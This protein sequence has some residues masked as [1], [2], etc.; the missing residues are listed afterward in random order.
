MR[1][2]RSADGRR[3]MSARFGR[4]RKTLI[5]KGGMIATATS[6]AADGFTIE[7]ATSLAKGAI[8]MKQ[9]LSSSDTN[10]TFSRINAVFQQMNA[11]DYHIYVAWYLDG[12]LYSD[13]DPSRDFLRNAAAKIYI[14]VGKNPTGTGTGRQTLCF[15]PD[16]NI[17]VYARDKDLNPKWIKLINDKKLNT[18]RVMFFDKPDTLSIE[19]M[20]LENEGAAD[21]GVG[22]VDIHV[23]G[24]S[25]PIKA[26]RTCI[27]YLQPSPQVEL[28]NVEA[29]CEIYE[30]TKPVFTEIGGKS[31][32]VL[33]NF[34]YDFPEFI[35]LDDTYV[36]ESYVLVCTHPITYGISGLNVPCMWFT[37]L[38]KDFI[39]SIFE[40]TMQETAYFDNLP[41]IGKTLCAL[42]FAGSRSHIKAVHAED[43]L[44]NSIISDAMKNI[45]Y[46]QV[47]KLVVAL[48]A[49]LPSGIGTC[50]KVIDAVKSLS[51][52]I[53]SGEEFSAIH[54]VISA[55][56]KNN[57]LDFALFFKVFNVLPLIMIAYLK[58]HFMEY[59]NDEL[60]LSSK[61]VLSHEEIFNMLAHP[62]EQIQK[63]NLYLKLNISSL[64][65][66]NQLTGSLF[67]SG[68]TVTKPVFL[69]FIRNHPGYIQRILNNLS[70]CI[71][72][73]GPFVYDLYKDSSKSANTLLLVAVVEITQ[74]PGS[75][76]IVVLKL[77]PKIYV[78]PEEKVTYTVI[79]GY[80]SPHKYLCFVNYQSMRKFI[81]E[82][83]K[84]TAVEQQPTTKS[85]ITRLMS[86]MHNKSKPTTSKNEARLRYTDTLLAK[87][88]TSLEDVVR[89][90]IR[91]TDTV[92]R[93]R[94]CLESDI[95]TRIK[96]LEWL[97]LSTLPSTKPINNDDT[98]ILKACQDSIKSP[99]STLDQTYFRVKVEKQQSNKGNS[100]DATSDDATTKPAANKIPNNNRELD[101]RFPVKVEKKQ[102]YKGTS[103][104]ETNNAT[105]KPA[106]YK[107]PNNDMNLDAETNK[108]SIHNPMTGS[109]YRMMAT[110]I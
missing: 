31:N 98:T 45:D 2:E 43:N 46:A 26:S 81:Q 10:N 69:E 48:G 4:N 102:S 110:S 60:T 91:L 54:K 18:K 86:I 66:F 84:T 23:A 71:L 88:E 100:D 58:Q 94:Q 92:S 104:D 37:K 101:V 27:Q 7:N 30:C 11:S 47:E 16:N 99:F 25:Q 24:V 15:S 67:N 61:P 109:A 38:E 106:A 32:K 80:M 22:D 76:N 87:F 83:G 105:T 93:R 28:N 68:D 41:V 59:L 74:K 36:Q 77:S 56:R 20:V 21:S 103:D 75:C 29:E 34:K 52:S 79:E 50:F 63:N 82:C 65:L 96:M 44:T 107:I 64:Q 42:S 62:Y 55:I 51:D 12:H 73:H 78:S 53:T 9:A 90:Y 8:H 85:I 3:N 72:R 17:C 5:K 40:G 39:R 33:Q 70:V 89:N 97:L 108:F 14:F 57:D 49:N 1:N 19:V 95:K 6:I 35:Q 13:I